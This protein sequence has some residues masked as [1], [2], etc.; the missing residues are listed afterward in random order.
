MNIL[1]SVVTASLMI[2][3]IYVSLMLTAS[4]DIRDVRL[5]IVT[6]VVYSAIAVAWII[7]AVGRMRR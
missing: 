3:I 6:L 7:K 5:G 4:S 1:P 2:V